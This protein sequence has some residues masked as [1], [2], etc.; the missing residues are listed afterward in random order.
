MS[1][2]RTRPSR[3]G[4]RT[5]SRRERLVREQVEAPVRGSRPERPRR[6]ISL[7]QRTALWSS[8]CGLG[9]LSIVVAIIGFH[10]TLFAGIGAVAITTAYSYGLAA[11]TGGRTVIAGLLGLVLGVAVFVVDADQMRAGAAVMMAV[12]SAV[13]AVMGTTPA[14]T[15]V[16]AAREC[17]VA[18]VVA[19]LGSLAAIGYA[20]VVTVNRFQYAALALA[21]IGIFLLVY[22]LGAG[23]HGLGRRGLAT[24]AGGAV[25][26]LATLL[27]A[28]AIRRYGTP[29]LIG[30]LR[31]G[32][33]S[34]RDHLGGYPRPIEALLGIPA[35]AWGTHMRAR[36]RQ[37][38][39]VCAFGVAA[40]APMAS[41]F[42]NPEVSI[43]EGVLSICY[44]VVVG[45]II[46]Y[47]VVRADLFLTGG[48]ARPGRG[49]AASGQAVAPGRRAARQAEE[50]AAVRPEPRRTQ[51]LL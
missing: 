9:T 6:R 43:L 2:P 11:R 12:L 3:R 18:T 34:L 7:R 19:V 22:R 21:L 35:L 13:F 1:S 10:E 24:V 46:G 50:A 17:L 5:G 30:T 41:T 45:L 48:Y 20:P 39:W 44:S 27:Y 51:A 49:P 28:E 14:V 29:G 23:L 4:T 25:L 16:K 8:L 40:T 31:D 26:L 33:V 15:F 42:V 37:G 32:V 47:V 36:R 38:W